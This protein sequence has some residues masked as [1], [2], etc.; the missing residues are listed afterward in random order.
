MH[1]DIARSALV[2]SPRA[3]VWA[4]LLDFERVA[5][6]LTVVG[7]VREVEPLRRYPAVLED[8]V[9]PSALRAALAATVTATGP[10]LHAEA[11]GEDRQVASRIAATIDLPVSDAAG[12]RHVA[13]TR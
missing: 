13:G 9:G 12:A 7:E 2:A 1:Q 4:A 8:R 6:W 3:H 11:S 10:R 5:S